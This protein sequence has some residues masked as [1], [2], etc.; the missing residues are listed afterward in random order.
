MVTMTLMSECK[1]G[2]HGKCPGR[3]NAPPGHPFDG[4]IC[5]CSCHWKKDEAGAADN[6]EIELEFWR[7][8]KKTARICTTSRST[9]SSFRQDSSLAWRSKGSRNS[10]KKG[11]AQL[12][13]ACC[14]VSVIA[15]DALT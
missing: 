5:D 9:S 15:A 2:Q 12:N 4:V 10:R 11:E 1:A 13:R 7:A 8:I 14:H 3:R 6:S